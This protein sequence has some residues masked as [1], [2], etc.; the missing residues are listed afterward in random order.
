[1]RRATTL[2]LLPLLVAFGPAEDV[3]LPKKGDATPSLNK[4]VEAACGD[5][6][7]RTIRLPAGKYSFLTEPKPIPCAVN[8]IGE[9][10]GTTSLIRRF[11]A[12]SLLHFTRGVDQ[13]GGSVRKIALLAGEGTTD[14][15]ALMIEALP[16]TDASQNSFNRHNFVIEEV[17]VGRESPAPATSWRHGIVLDGSRNPDGNPGI[18]PGIRGAHIDKV[19]V[20]GT[21]L[22][23][24]LLVKARGIYLNVE[25]YIPLGEFNGVIANDLVDGVTMF[26]RSC[27]I[28]SDTGDVK[29]VMINGHPQ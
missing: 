5:E 15:V 17:M 13:F 22:S 20:S 4:A 18:A 24:F 26:T 2:F 28:R 8:I 19:T 25:C 21:E 9:G 29:S 14:G 3:R 1:M 11:E 27:S 10:R 16:D 7:N 12:G 23:Q 6:H